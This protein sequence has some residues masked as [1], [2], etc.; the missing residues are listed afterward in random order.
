MTSDPH[1]LDPVRPAYFD[2]YATIA[3]T[4]T[5][6]GVLLIRLH[7]DDGPVRYGSTHHNDWSHAFGD[8]AADRGNRVVVITGT[9]DSF[10]AAHSSW[11]EPLDRALDYDRAT[12]RHPRIYRSLLEID[13][14]VIAAVNGPCF[15]H[16]QVPL[17]SDIV[18][19]ADTTVF[20]D[21]YLP[22]STDPTSEWPPSL[23]EPATD[24]NHVLWLELLGQIRGTYFLL[25]SHRLTAVEARHLGVVNEIW[26]LPELLPRALELAHQLATYAD[27]TLRF[28]RRAFTDRWRRLFADRIGIAHAMLMRTQVD[29]DRRAMP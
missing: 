16:S 8:V 20:G 7:S 5:A 25:T 28:Q 2:A 23:G 12:I 26:P 1:G 6:D 21:G 17:L 10:V 13:A 9:G 27:L 19:A 15:Y 4:R 22:G 11:D 18:L 24:G 14:P 3:F 29:L